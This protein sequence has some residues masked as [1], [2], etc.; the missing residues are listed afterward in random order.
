MGIE[1]TGFPS[2]SIAEVQDTWLGGRSG[3]AENRQTVPG[4]SFE[5]AL[6]K[7]AAHSEPLR[8]SKHAASRLSFRGIEMTENQLDRLNIAKLQAKEKGINESLIMVDELAFIV[9]VPNNT[10]VTAMDRTA[11]PNSI[12]TNIDGAVIA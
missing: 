2:R 1:S 9:N 6:S 8:F 10:V 11:E 7:A 12:F 4:D 3:K 5:A